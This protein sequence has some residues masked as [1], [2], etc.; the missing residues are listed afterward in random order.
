MINN[1]YWCQF[2][3]SGDWLIE[4]NREV[5][6]KGKFYMWTVIHS[7]IVLPQKHHRQKKMNA[8][9]HTV[10]DN[11]CTN[12]RCGTSRISRLRLTCWRSMMILLN[13]FARESWKTKKTNAGAHVPCRNYTTVD[14]CWVVF[15]AILTDKVRHLGNGNFSFD[16]PFPMTT[17]L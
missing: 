16:T 7:F 15:V 4:N 10:P 9:A 12:N 14:C 11:K 13:W 2:S 6:I 5:K 8:I 3:R 1:K 17:P